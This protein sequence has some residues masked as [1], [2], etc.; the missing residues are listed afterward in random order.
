MIRQ[1]ILH[2][3]DGR[4]VGA[5]QKLCRQHLARQAVGE[6]RT[7]PDEQEARAE[8]CGEG[9]LMRDEHDGLA[10]CTKLA[11]K[12][13]DF[14][15]I[16][17]VQSR[18]RLIE[19]EHGRLLRE[20]LGEQHALALSAR[21][22]LKRLLR[23]FRDARVRHARLSDGDI[24]RLLLP[25]PREI[26]IASREHDLARRIIERHLQMLLQISGALRKLLRRQIADSL[27]HDRDLARER[28]QDAAHR[29]QKRALAR[30]VRP[31]ETDHLARCNAERDVLQD[32]LPLIARI[33]AL[34]PYH[35]LQIPPLLCS[36]STDKSSCLSS[37]IRAT[38]FIRVSFMTS[39]TSIV[40]AE[41]DRSR[42]APR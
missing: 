24:V 35:F 10:R 3:F 23:Q 21:H 11:A 16:D 12:T 13:E 41:C 42:A 22:G 15:L 6:E 7:A 2:D 25:P 19:K 28:R 38:L 26:R 29:L 27:S 8:A 9:K 37:G 20:Y 31:D 5:C 4:T 34:N 30:A 1:R 32:H 39:I 18:C 40:V 14:L 36:E 17:D 33:K